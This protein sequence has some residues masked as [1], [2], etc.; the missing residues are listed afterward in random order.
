MFQSR[1]VPVS[2]ST[3]LSESQSKRLGQDRIRRYRYGYTLDWQTMRL[4]HK[5][6]GFTPTA[7]SYGQLGAGGRGSRG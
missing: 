3:S 7:T 1:C 2:L 4:R 5:P 6:R